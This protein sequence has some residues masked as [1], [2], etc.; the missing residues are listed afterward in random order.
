MV[1]CRAVINDWKKVQRVLQIYETTTGQ[2]IN[3]HKTGAFFS[4]NTSEAMKNQ[5]LEVSRVSLCNNQEKYLGLP[6]LVGKNKYWTFEAI[7]DRVW[8]Q[9]KNWKHIFLSQASKEILLLKSIIQAI[10]SYSMSMFA[11]PQKNV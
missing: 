11:L 6:I 7:K 8:A 4:S 1:F 9:V 10:S 2:G 3:L 5:L